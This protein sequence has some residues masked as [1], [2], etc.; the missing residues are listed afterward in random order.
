MKK[1]IRKLLVRRET[2]R[3]LCALNNREL[4]RA[5]SGQLETGDHC[6]APQQQPLPVP[7][8]H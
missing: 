7:D 3:A 2:I 4:A 8:R 1:I 5:I 6:P